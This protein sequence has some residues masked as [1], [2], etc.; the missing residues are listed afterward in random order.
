MIKQVGSRELA[1]SWH[2]TTLRACISSLVTLKVALF[3]TISRKIGQN[4]K[5]AIVTKKQL[6]CALTIADLRVGDFNNQY[7]K[8]KYRWARG[9]KTVMTKI[10]V[11]VFG[12]FAL[13]LANLVRCV[14]AQTRF[15]LRELWAGPPRSSSYASR[16]FRICAPFSCMRARIRTCIRHSFCR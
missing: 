1:M 6:L 9:L 12:F 11:F 15:F 13:L 5:S 14:P 7:L 2:Y 10:A 8:R 4:Q 3:Y 16:L